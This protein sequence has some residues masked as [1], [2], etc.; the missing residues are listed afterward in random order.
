MQL[1]GKEKTH[2]QKSAL[3]RVQIKGHL[4]VYASFMGRSQRSLKEDMHCS[5][6]FT[7]PS[8]CSCV[9]EL[10]F[11]KEPETGIRI[12]GPGRREGVV[13]PAGWRWWGRGPEE[14]SSQRRS[15]R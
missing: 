5:H 3:Q 10:R 8:R 2:T 14:A 15:F 4:W 9:K 1:S 12:P 7:S 13:S 11:T 6:S